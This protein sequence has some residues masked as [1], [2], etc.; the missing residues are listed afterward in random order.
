MNVSEKVRKAAE[1][2]AASPEHKEH[3]RKIAAAH[4]Q[5]KHIDLPSVMA[6]PHGEFPEELISS[7]GELRSTWEDVLAFQIEYKGARDE[8]N[9]S[10]SV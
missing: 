10:A 4:E 1:R 8:N 3:Q 5:L 2:L 9:P 7:E 6:A